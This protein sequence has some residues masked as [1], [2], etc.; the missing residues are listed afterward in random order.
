VY[1]TGWIKR[2]P[3]G[4]IGTNK[5]CAAET[6]EAMVEDLGRGAV[7][8]PEQPDSA[9]WEAFVRQ[10]RPQVITFE[11]WRQLDVQELKRGKEQ[12]R[13]RV[14]LTRVDEML[15]AVGK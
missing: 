9:A 4:V 5:P 11:Q 15:A 7:P 8:S 3:S 1:V 10:R 12:G 13:P 2:G 6:V 14:K